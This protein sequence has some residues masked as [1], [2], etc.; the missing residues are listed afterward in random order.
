MNGPT[1]AQELAVLQSVTY[2]SLFDYP[3]TLSQLRDSLIGERAD[4][5]TI[6]RWVATSPLLQATIQR[7]NDLY[8]PAGRVDLLATR[9]RRE[10]L[11]RRL[12]E[13]DQKIL[14][15]IAALPFVR[16]VAVSGSLAHLNA[17][18]ESDLDLFVITRPGRVW[19]VTL[20]A[21]IVSRLLGWRRRLCLN[22]I[23]SEASLGIEP[24]DLFSANQII[25]LRPI[26]GQ[27]V[28][29]RFLEANAFVRGFYPNFMPREMHTSTWRP[30]RWKGTAAIEA[31]LNLGVAQA[32]D[33]LSRVIYTRHL[34]RKSSQWQSRDQVR[35]DRECLKLHTSSHRNSTIARFDNAVAEALRVAEI[36]QRLIG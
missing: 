15:F 32:A 13:R 24:G 31:V 8:F 3:L 9:R 29:R 18:G 14:Q 6:A 26:I 19:L 7:Q 4:E 16:L 2:A 34:R 35:L 21:L 22:Y 28:Y 36:K 23:V 1:Y 20:A 17:E 11:S 12:L 25:H 33:R 10:E 30:S 5:P 27:E